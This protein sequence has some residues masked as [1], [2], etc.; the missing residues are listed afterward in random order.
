MSAE[1]FPRLSSLPLL[2]VSD[3]TRVHT[4]S[5]RSSTKLCND[6]EQRWMTRKRFVCT[7]REN[8]QKQPRPCLLDDDN[9]HRVASAARVVHAGSSSGPQLSAP[10]HQPVDF[11]R[12]SY[13]CARFRWQE[14]QKT[15]NRA[16]FVSQRCWREQDS[17]QWCS[18]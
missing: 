1:T 9:E 13:L 5:G 17:S 15:G 18:T 3:D 10:L 16:R 14:A 7:G 6:Y 11:A 12:S 8:L 4:Y 2:Q